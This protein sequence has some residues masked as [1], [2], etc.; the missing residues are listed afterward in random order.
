MNSGTQ[1]V[2]S[3]VISQL[4][5]LCL[6]VVRYYVLSAIT[7]HTTHTTFGRMRNPRKTST[8]LLALQT[9]VVLL[10]LFYTLLMACVAPKPLALEKARQP[11]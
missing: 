3:Q 11:S 5:G 8:G 6:R 10:L 7:H 1:Q 2:F 4:L 9:A